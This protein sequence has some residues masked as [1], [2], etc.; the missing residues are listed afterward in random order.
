MFQTTKIHLNWEITFL[1]TNAPV[2]PTLCNVNNKKNFILETFDYVKIDM[3]KYRSSEG[4]DY[5][6]TEKLDK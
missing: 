1:S 5:V 2:Y 3:G 6:V 4:F